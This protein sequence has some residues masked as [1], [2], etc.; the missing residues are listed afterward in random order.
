MNLESTIVS[1]VQGGAS[2]VT[3]ALLIYIL[4]GLMGMGFTGLCIASFAQ[5]FTRWVA[6]LV[7]MKM[8]SNPK[9][10]SQKDVP[11]FTKATITDLGFQAK[12]AVLQCTMGVWQ[13]L[14]LEAFVFM[15]S[16]V[17]TAALAATSVLRA[18]SQF[19]YMIPLG[20]RL[21]T[22]I[23]IGKKIGEMSEPACRHFYNV[24][25]K[26]GL[27]YAGICALLFS[28]FGR[29]ICMIFTQD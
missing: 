19:T 9:I 15:S 25:L 5:F 26:M 17:S 4:V 10:R 27:I 18:I 12:I 20:L 22:I 28:I 2:T 1:L 6:T 8:T 7:F 13:W 16:Y 3:H 21:A 23:L 14:G 24:S 11:F 29:T